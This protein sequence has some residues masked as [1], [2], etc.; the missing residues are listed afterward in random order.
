SRGRALAMWRR[1]PMYLRSRRQPVSNEDGSVRVVFNGE[2]YNFHELRRAL[3][4]RGHTF[5]TTSDTE[6]IVHLYE[7]LG[8]RCVDRL[9]GMFAFAVWDAR[10]RQLLIARDR[11]GI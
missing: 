3:L 8:P 5:S 4:G 1:T 2:I 9:R 11:L 6:V 10:Q 7:E